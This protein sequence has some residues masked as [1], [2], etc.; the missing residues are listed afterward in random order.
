MLKS[1][2]IIFTPSLFFQY[3][4]C[5]H[6]LWHERFSDPKKKGDI[7]ELTQKLLEQGVVHEEDYIEGMDFEEVKIKDPNKAF[8]ETIRLMQAGADLIY[9]GEIQ[10]E[11]DGVIYRGRPDLLKKKRGKSTFGNWYYR[12]IDIKSSRAIKPEQ[13]LQLVLYADILEVVQ[14]RF[15]TEVAIIN[16][17]KEMVEVEIEEK[18]RMKMEKRISEMLSIMAGDK[19]PLKLA[20]KCKQSPWFAECIHEAE[21]AEDLALIYNLDARSHIRLRQNNINTIHDVAIMDVESLPKIPHASLETLKR[22]KMQAQSLLDDKVLWRVQPDI[23]DAPLKLY[24]DI[25]GDPLLQLEYMFGFWVVGDPKGQYA[26]IG[27][28]RQY[29]D[30]YFI[31]FL[32]EQPEDEEKTWNELIQWIKLL[33]KEGYKVYHF[34]DYERSHTIK[35]AANYGSSRAFNNFAKH[36]ID[37]SKIVQASVILPLYFYS[38][39]NIAKSRFLKFKWRHEKAGGAQSIFW[40]EEWLATGNKAILDDI[41]NYNED[42]VRATEHLHKWLIKYK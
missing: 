35:L 29:K 33:P 24:F 22:A 19:P 3:S 34:A 2:K 39:K 27:Q 5:P 7:P 13:M 32:A 10:Y 18:H 26:K 4:T 12:P 40:Y 17:D 23:P 38:I 11:K 21:K 31:Y 37:L 14:G 8:R 42:D 16:R 25:E 15:P 1:K 41:I 36:Y 9:Q 20:S 28:V 6:W 30:K